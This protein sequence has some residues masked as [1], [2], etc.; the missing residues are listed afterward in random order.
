MK[1]SV[2]ID[3][4]PDSVWRY[5]EGWA[6]VAVDV[7]RATTTAITAAANGWRCYPAPNTEAALDIA[8]RFHNPLLAGEVSGDVPAPF[9]MDN[10]PAQLAGRTD[11]HRPLVLVSSS[12]T[13]VIHEAA[14]CE[15][16][17]LSCF[18]SHSVLPGYLAARHNR[19]AVIGAGTKGEFR[20]EDQICCAWIA[21]ALLSKGF[22]P[23]S[24]ETMEVVNRW[25]SAP[26][27]ACLCS[28]SVGFLKRTGRH[29]DL[30]FIMNHIDDLRAVFTVEDGEVKMIPEE[31]ATAPRP[32]VEAPATSW[33]PVRS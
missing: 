29:G 16:T 31:P 6:V 10:S 17:Y 9:E 24:S 15:A 7:I 20:E 1:T 33:A 14:G 11:T 28:G 30:D 18:R 21:A 13:R 26:P 32:C 25:G 12:G 27:K 5:K 3:Y 4:L 23:E 19:V 22:S 8:Q 2:V